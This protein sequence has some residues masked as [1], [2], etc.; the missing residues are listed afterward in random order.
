MSQRTLASRC[1]QGNAVHIVEVNT[2]T[3][4]KLVPE[5]AKKIMLD[6]VL[7]QGKRAALWVRDC[8]QSDT[9]ELD[10]RF[11]TLSHSLVSGEQW[12]LHRLICV[13]GDPE[14]NTDE[15]EM[16]QDFYKTMYREAKWCGVPEE[17]FSDYLKGEGLA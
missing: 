15:W 8:S 3:A 12:S 13:P 16:I 5:E 11:A 9:D 17:S 4:T 2:E 10:I 1:Q 6:A 7:I 14:P